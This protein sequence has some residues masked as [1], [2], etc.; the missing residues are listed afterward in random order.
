MIFGVFT[1]QRSADGRRHTQTTT[2][3]CMSPIP[4]TKDDVDK[5]APQKL[6][7]RV[8]VAGVRA[9]VGFSNWQR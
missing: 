1:S 7:Y 5:L 6:T 3:Q 8:L 2:R 4:V 9:T